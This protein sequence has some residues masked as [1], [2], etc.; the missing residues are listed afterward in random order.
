M[1]HVAALALLIG[2]GNGRDVVCSCRC[3]VPV[4]A[5]APAPAVVPEVALP[6][7]HVPEPRPE[8]L[9]K[10]ALAFNIGFASAV[11]EIGVT[12]MLTPIAPFEIEIGVGRGYSGTQLSFMGKLTFGSRTHRAT[13]GIGIAST[14]APS[15]VTRDNP[16]WLNADILGYE[17]RADSRFFFAAAVGLYKGLGGGG[18][19][20]GDCEGGN[21]Y[22]VDVTR[23]VGFQGRLM[24]GATF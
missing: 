6:A 8:A 24:V 21:Q 17:F 10:N 23:L 22:A 2:D 19:C 20:Q 13:T 1:W 14:V 9:P 12:Y 3:E 11:G 5:P 4:A 16:I 18:V 7:P 15:D